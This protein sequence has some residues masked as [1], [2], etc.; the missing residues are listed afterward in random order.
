MGQPPVYVLPST[1]IRRGGERL[2]NRRHLMI[3]LFFRLP[4]NHRRSVQAE[5]EPVQF[6]TFGKALPH[7]FRK[8]QNRR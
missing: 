3:G 2:N 6:V 5:L 4:V 8:F 1:R 7:T